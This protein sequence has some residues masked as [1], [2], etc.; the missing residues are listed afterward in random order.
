MTELMTTFYERAATFSTLVGGAAGHW[1]DP[2]PCEGWTAADVVAHVIETERDF[3]ARRGI[4]VGAAPD[5]RDPLDA[6]TNHLAAVRRLL[7]DATL[8]TATYDGWFGPTSI[9]NMMNDFYGWD[10][11]VHG[12]DL[13]SA[14][15]QGNPI[16]EDLAESL[17]KGADAWGAAL[18]GEGVC[19]T[20]VAIDPGADATD[21][22]LARLGRDP[23]WSS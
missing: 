17:D 14:T 6:W 3:L 20:A 13:A 16:T 1:D 11:A 5:L 15:G 10:L 23:E 21:R 9:E 4:D 12:W 22:L 2:S 18:Y 7:A 8:V 19:G